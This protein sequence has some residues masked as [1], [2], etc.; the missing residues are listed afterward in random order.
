M[1]GGSGDPEGGDPPGDPPPGQQSAGN[2]HAPAGVSGRDLCPPGAPIRQPGLGVC[3][4]CAVRSHK[5]GKRGQRRPD[6][7]DGH[8]R[9]ADREFHAAQ[10]LMGDEMQLKKFPAVR[11][12]LFNIY[13]N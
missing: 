1:P 6:P 3:A 2:H 13:L 9:W 7:A 5:R 12:A 4:L 10:I 11:L 8:S